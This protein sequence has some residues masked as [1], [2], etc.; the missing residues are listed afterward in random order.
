MNHQ[1]KIFLQQK[2]K[3]GFTLYNLYVDAYIAHEIKAVLRLIDSLAL[4]VLYSSLVDFYYIGPY[5]I[6]LVGSIKYVCNSS[7]IKA[8][9]IYK[10]YLSINAM[11]SDLIGFIN[12]FTRVLCQDYNNYLAS[13]SIYNERCFLHLRKS[14]NDS[15]LL[16]CREHLGSYEY[17]QLKN[18]GLIIPK[19]INSVQNNESE[20][21]EIKNRNII[22]YMK[23]K[24]IAKK[25]E[26]FGINNYKNDKNFESNEFSNKNNDIINKLNFSVVTNN[27]DFPSE[28]QILFDEN[29]AKDK[30]KRDADECRENTNVFDF[31][32]NA[33]INN[34]REEIKNNYKYNNIQE[35]RN[36]NIFFESDKNIADNSFIS[37]KDNE[38]ENSIRNNEDFLQRAKTQKIVSKN[39]ELI[40]NINFEELNNDEIDGDNMMNINEKYSNYE[41]GLRNSLMSNFKK[42]NNHYKEEINNFNFLQQVF[43]NNGN[44]NDIKYFR[45]NSVNIWA[46]NNINNSD[47]NDNTINSINNN[48][49]NRYINDNSADY[50]RNNNDKIH[51]PNNINKQNNIYYL[52]QINDIRSAL[53]SFQQNYNNN[54]QNNNSFNNVNKSVNNQ[55]NFNEFDLSFL[56]GY[57]KTSNSSEDYLKIN[58]SNPSI[59]SE[60]KEK[61][62]FYHSLSSSNINQPFKASFKGYLGIN[63]KPPKVINNKIFYI[64]ILN[65]NWKDHN[66]FTE[67]KINQSIEQITGMIYRIQLRKEKSAIKLMTYSLNQNI[68]SQMKKIDV[69]INL[70]NNLL[71]YKFYYK[72]QINNFVKRIEIKVE[73]KNNYYLDCK[74]LKSDGNIMDNNGKET[75]VA[76]NGYIN[77]GKILFEENNIRVN[78][79]INKINIMIKLKNISISNMDAKIN[80][81][82]ANNQSPEA[83]FGQKLSLMCFQYE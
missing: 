53:P 80:F 48:R 35:K 12:G 63:I 21:V 27:L 4:V 73:C 43:N 9:T 61:L 54:I 76:Y 30:Y 5:L 60:L 69:M 11:I 37:R 83:L 55:N 82:N 57:S 51:F 49:I 34:K 20:K 59:I 67:R 42:I 17:N 32:N 40:K 25:R 74:N 64:N 75:I 47:I 3:N 78:D 18:M 41:H 77:D 50:I 1:L 26:Y 46:N 81:S 13:E 56:N 70:Y 14:N 65:E 2:P 45:N 36:N 24:K 71:T 66:Y 68:V 22:N 15:M 52:T 44:R 7:E 79:Y 19:N 72:Q 28:S 33:A 58:P 23:F 39:M 6:N 31:I 29:E 62:Y 16:M 38:Y 10:N 8:K